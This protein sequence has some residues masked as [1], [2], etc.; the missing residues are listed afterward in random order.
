MIIGKTFSNLQ[1]SAEVKLAE[2][3]PI[4]NFAAGSTAKTILELAN[5]GISTAY[6]AVRESAEQAY[7]STA[8]GQYL[9]L[10]GDLLSIRRKENTFA[11]TTAYERNVKFYTADGN[12]IKSVMA[13]AS[14]DTGIIPA[15]TII[16]TSGTQGQA[17]LRYRVFEDYD[18]G[19][20][21]VLY[22]TVVAESSSSTSNVGKGQ[23]SQHDLGI[24]GLLVTNDY[25]IVNGEGREGDD[26]YR[27]RIKNQIL[28]LQKANESAV[29]LAVLQIVGIA[30]ATVV[31]YS[32]GVG[33]YDVYIEPIGGGLANPNL[34]GAAQERIEEVQAAGIFGIVR[35]PDLVKTT[36][37]LQLGYLPNATTSDISLARLRARDAVLSYLS[38]LAMGETM[39]VN[40]LLSVSTNSSEYIGTTNIRS[41]TFN[42]RDGFARDYTPRWNEKIYPSEDVADPVSII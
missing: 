11:N 4:K 29:E 3:T 21:S 19:E 23:L 34:I 15:N 2:K 13:A 40:Q 28:G 17:P 8:S 41:I 31:P 22:V 12:S 9:D 30:N 18:Y 16:Y 35:N 36:I 32:R 14:Q 6:G 38:G 33:T 1:T 10:I 26:E 7:L 24:D 27:Y 37:S 20:Q 42:G 25:P 5:G 39:I